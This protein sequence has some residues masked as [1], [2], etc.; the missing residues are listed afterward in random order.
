L[1]FPEPHWPQ[2]IR[3]VQNVLLD[4]KRWDRFHF[5]SGDTVVVSWARSGTTLTQQIVAQLIFGGDKDLMGASVSPWIELRVPPDTIVA[6]N[7]QTHRRILKTHLPLPA[8]VFSPKA[9][10]LYVGRDPRDVL[11]SM[12]HHHSSFTAQ[13]YDRFNGVPGRVGPA[14]E[15][16]NPDV[17]AYY[18]EWLDRDG[19]PFWP[20]WS[21]VQGWWNAR[22]LPNVLLL[23]FA[24]LTQDLPREIRRVAAFLDLEVDAELLSRTQR[25]CD[26]EFM[27]R[28]A[29][30]V[31]ALN[32]L[33][34]GGGRAFVYKGTTGRWR[35]VLSD[36]E[37]AKCDSIAARELSP[38][39][40]R[41]LRNGTGA[42]N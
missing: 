38:D 20:F 18:H 36:E 35:D 25:H 13:A 17:R 4:S 19:Y 6:A 27:R 3:E 21:H 8:L 33:F 42:E 41:W 16:P 5:R 26:L 1:L 7:S 22:H 2:K 34:Q 29:S 14:L 30:K 32:V 24:D 31:T 37:I 40:A 15:P 10:Y 12:H 9:K 39:C 23:H 11:W 28:Q